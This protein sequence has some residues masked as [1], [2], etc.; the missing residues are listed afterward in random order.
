MQ[1]R[2]KKWY[3]IRINSLA[4]ILSDSQLTKLIIKLE[5]NKP[6]PFVSGWSIAALANANLFIFYETLIQSPLNHWFGLVSHPD[7]YATIDI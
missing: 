4:N 3:I 2:K 5:E 1:K 7:I 6:Q